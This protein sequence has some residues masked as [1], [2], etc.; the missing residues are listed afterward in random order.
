[1]RL[2]KRCDGGH[3]NALFALEGGPAGGRRNMREG[4]R[5]WSRLNVRVRNHRL[6]TTTLRRATRYWPLGYLVNWQGPSG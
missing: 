3:K 1:M 2:R 4:R 6:D 5:V